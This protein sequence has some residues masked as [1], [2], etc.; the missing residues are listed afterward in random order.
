MT[1]YVYSFLSHEAF[2]GLALA[3]SPA[4]SLVHVHPWLWI[5][6]TTVV[7]WT[8]QAVSHLVLCLTTGFSF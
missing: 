2:C 8:H 1:V 3:Y 5:D 4:G 7:S 6:H